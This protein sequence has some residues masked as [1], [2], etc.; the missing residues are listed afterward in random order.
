VILAFIGV[1][2][3][4][5]FG[6]VQISTGVSLG[7][8]GVVLAITTVASLRRS[9]RDPSARAHAGSMRETRPREPEAA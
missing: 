3:V 7:V 9:R 6:H 1:K 4:L 8:I 5:H 2:L